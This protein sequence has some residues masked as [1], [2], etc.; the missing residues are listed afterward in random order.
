MD[1][2]FLQLY[3]SLKSH[4]VL[5][6]VVGIVFVALCGL[7]ASKLQFQE[8]ITELLPSNERSETLK[9]VLG[10]IEFSDKITLHI[11]SK[12]PEQA[13]LLAAYAEFFLDS[14]EVYQE[15]Y[16]AQI[17]GKIGTESLL[18]TYNFVSEN[19]PLFLDGEDYK[20]IQERLQADSISSRVKTGH[21][22]LM[23]PA[24]MIA[25]NY[26]LKDPMQFTVLGLDKLR[27]LQVG[28]NF[29]LHKGFLLTKDKK[30]L[31]LFIEPK[32]PG[33]ETAENTLF[34]KNLKNTVSKLNQS[35]GTIN[36][37]LTG[38]AL[39]S[40]ANAE[41][42]KKDIRIT[43]GIAMGVL[44][45]ILIGFYRN[46][47]VPLILFIPTFVGALTALALLSLLKGEISAISLGIGSVLL[48]VTLDYSLHILTHSRSVPTAKQLFKDTSLPIVTTALTAATAFL[49]LLFVKSNA[50][51][52]LG[53]FAAVSLLVSAVVALIVVPQFYRPKKVA[54]NSKN[55]IIDRFAS[56]DFHESRF[57]LLFLAGVFLA[58]LFF[59]NEVKFDQ[60]LSSLNY[61]PEELLKAEK[62]LL[63]I[64][65]DG[66]KS[67]YLVSYGNSVNQALEVNNKLHEKL[68]KAKEA[69][70]IETYSSLGGIV[71]S[72]KAQQ[73][74]IDDWNK[75]WAHGKKESL[76]K[77]LIS[78]SMELGYKKDAFKG[79]FKILEKDFKPI[80]FLD[81]KAVPNLFIDEFVS[82]DEGFSTVVSVVKM[83]SGKNT[84]LWENF[85]KSENVLAI[86]REKLNESFLG[87]LKND[88]NK[89]INYS[90]IAVFLILLISYR[91]LELTL[92][93]LAPI[94]V[95]WTIALA[96]MDVLN[97]PFNFLNIMVATFVFGFGVDYSIF[98][99]K[100]LRKK[101]KTGV[102]ELKTF[103][104]AIILSVIVNLLGIGVLVFA[105]HPALKSIAVVSIIGISTAALVPF[106]LLPFLFETF[107]SGRAKK[108]LRPLRLRQSL[109]SGFSF[110]YF[111][112]GAC[113]LSVFAVLLIP[114]FPVKRER[115]MLFFHKTLSGFMK[116][117]LYTNGF[118][119]KRI[120][121][122][123][124]ENFEKP[125]VIIANHSS[126]LD[127]LV[128][129][130]LH[131]KLV[132]LVNDW[133]YDSPVFGR[134]VKLAGFYPVSKG[135][136]NGL[137]F[138]R[139]KTAQ[140]YSL[141]VFPEGSRSRTGKIGRFHKG[142]FYLAEKLKLDLLPVLIHGTAQVLPK[143]DFIVHDGKINVGI[144]KRI[145][146]EDASFGKN[147]R[148][149]SKNI[150]AY[151]R[152]EH[153]KLK[154]ETE[155]GNCLKQAVLDNYRYKN[156]FHKIKKRY[157]MEKAL[158]PKI[159]SFLETRDRVLQLGSAKGLLVFYLGFRKPS[160]K[161]I[162]YEENAE[163]LQASKQGY[164][165]FRQQV[166]FTGKIDLET[167]KPNVLLIST[168]VDL[169]K[170]L[171]YIK[172]HV[173]KI[174]IAEPMFEYKWLLALG[175]E[176]KS[177]QTGFV[178][179]KK[180]HDA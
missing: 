80:G 168:Q 66:S 31:L 5:A 109:H 85:G 122:F 9:K 103:R 33:T 148:E 48:G 110:L 58:G 174:I 22:T 17:Q 15:K 41:Q 91:N 64:T 171:D 4:K 108:G 162:G 2:F 124:N 1:Q 62:E 67:I 144:L 178:A 118:V 164:A 131:P 71:L 169:K 38:A 172:L 139:E 28:S 42:V 175:F 180:V 142:A 70:R 111:G 176:T 116:S 84:T 69:G 18:G 90:A 45:I 143:G 96:I 167:A 151:F 127:I 44:L 93:T 43:V 83:D 153:E 117:V 92:L 129:G 100:A 36:G 163:D 72:T 76:K 6:V 20:T 115:K 99:I 50:L 12:K 132:F 135:I 159:A 25:K 46:F 161:I 104:A 65:G 88:F 149:K 98:M 39:Y 97:I 68:S 29:E 126:F 87:T 10:Q 173:E 49:C 32:F 120:M 59:F 121:N 3:D 94:G 119:R 141:V 165:N 113:L 56:Y 147:Y 157:G 138:F 16:I 134:A 81:Y 24:G 102:S 136:D 34:V 19:L 86:D 137:E 75:F 47:F 166:S 101:Y 82:F 79:F 26:I 74:K 156:T 154:A 158:Y 54:P 146:F 35:F 105:E 95:T 140:G 128:L 7:L 123:H 155:T 77:R 73:E 8:D 61:Q 27:Q 21:K 52:D 60:D 130:M 125:C 114:V 63:E 152:S 23:S 107:I 150:V 37:K 30:N 14:V 13:D 160:L 179:L 51:W 57:L 78:E 106:I 40:V 11:S 112:L 145:P 55:S 53:I 177:A 170:H 133:V 89:L